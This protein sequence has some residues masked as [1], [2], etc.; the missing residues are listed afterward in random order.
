MKRALRAMGY[1]VVKAEDA[2]EALEVGRR[3]RPGLVL[4]K[5]IVGK[6]CVTMT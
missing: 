4:T 2:E 5:R 1:R 3:E 6:V